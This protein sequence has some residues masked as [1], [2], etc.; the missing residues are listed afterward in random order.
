MRG[1]CRG[2]AASSPQVR[3]AG[4]Q[5]PEEGGEAGRHAGLGA[6]QVADRVGDAPLH[7]G[8]KAVHPFQVAIEPFKDIAQLA[9]VVVDGPPGGGGIGLPRLLQIARHQGLFPFL[10][11]FQLPHPLQDLLAVAE[12]IVAGLE[13]LVVLDQDALHE[14]L[15]EAAQ[16]AAMVVTVAD[17]PQQPLEPVDHG[18]QVLDKA[19]RLPGRLAQGQHLGPGF[20]PGLLHI[21]EDGQ[22]HAAVEDPV[23]ARHLHQAAPESPHRRGH[24]DP[25][26][27][28]LQLLL[29]PA[30]G[31]QAAIGQGRRG[32]LMLA[33]GGRGAVRA[34]AS[35][36]CSSC[37]ATA[38]TASRSS[39][40]W[41][42]VSREGK[43]SAWI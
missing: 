28:A 41:R 21:V 38:M 2:L 11:I 26:P 19:A 1:R 6:I 29:H 16:D 24:R 30:G 14:V 12:G 15:E 18:V 10:V 27:I 9:D 34:S 17:V 13:T 31:Q 32:D 25:H 8:T 4:A 43:T 22:D 5:I 23:R 7:P 39:I 36:S 37:Q 40:S 33:G 35:G 20:F 42:T 3:Q